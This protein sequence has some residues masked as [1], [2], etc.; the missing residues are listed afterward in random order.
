MRRSAT[1][2]HLL[3]VLHPPYASL[4]PF[5]TLCQG[6][7]T[8][9]GFGRFRP[10]RGRVNAEADL[11]RRVQRWRN[12]QEQVDATRAEVRQAIERARKDGMTLDAIAAVVG[13]SRQR[14]LQILR[15]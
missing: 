2:R 8:Y 1:C 5:R 14:V 4:I 15:K 7:V 3:G 10:N 12:A 9:K 13:V 6:S 11:R